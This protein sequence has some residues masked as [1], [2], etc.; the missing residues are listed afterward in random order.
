MMWANMQVGWFDTIEELSLQI[1]DQAACENV[2]EQS[3]ARTCKFFR[4]SPRQMGAGDLVNIRGLMTD[5]RP[6]QALAVLSMLRPGS[7][8]PMPKI[9]S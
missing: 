3:V 7:T 9:M 4:H 2:T 6:F 8:W 5:P 1:K